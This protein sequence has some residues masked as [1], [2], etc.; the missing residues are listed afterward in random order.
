MCEGRKILLATDGQGNADDTSSIIGVF[1]A[2][3]G[4][5]LLE[6]KN[7]CRDRIPHTRL[8]S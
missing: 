7:V 6:F 5:Y 8:L 4:L 3:L 2:C 1:A